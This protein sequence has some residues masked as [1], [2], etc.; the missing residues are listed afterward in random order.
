M[1]CHL[2][3]NWTPFHGCDHYGPDDRI[4]VLPM[5]SELPKEFS[6]WCNMLAKFEERFAGTDTNDRTMIEVTL[7]YQAGDKRYYKFTI[8]E[9]KAKCFDE[10]REGA[11]NILSHE[12]AAIKDGPFH[13]ELI[14]A[15]LSRFIRNALCLHR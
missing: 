13:M 2:C 11:K 7:G 14:R 5:P 6:S 10:V 3:N 1:K 15:E 4:K 12:D 8:A 9:V